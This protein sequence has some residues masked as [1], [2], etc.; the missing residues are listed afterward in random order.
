MTSTKRAVGIAQLL[1]HDTC[2]VPEARVGQPAEYRDFAKNQRLR[3]VQLL[4]PSLPSMMI[5][6]VFV[7]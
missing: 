2:R 7:K 5:H 6:L 3:V 4:R 1:C